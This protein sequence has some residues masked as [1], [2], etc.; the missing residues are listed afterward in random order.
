MGQECN[1]CLR[2]IPSG[3]K[4]IKDID[5]SATLKKPICS[6]LTTEDQP[7]EISLNQF[8]INKK[9]KTQISASEEL[10]KIEEVVSIS[11]YESKL[12]EFKE[13]LQKKLSK[14]ARETDGKLEYLGFEKQLPNAVILDDGTI[15]QG[16]LIENSIKSGKGLEVLIDGSKYVGEFKNNSREGLGRL[17][18]PNGDYYEGEF[19]N[20]KFNGKGK[21]ISFEGVKFEG[22][23]KGD[24]KNGYGKEEWTDGSVY[25]GFYEGSFK[26]GHGKFKWKD[27]SYYEGEFTDNKI[28]GKGIYYWSNGKCFE[29]EW[30]EN[31]M[32]GFGIFTWPSGRKYEGEYKSDL[33]D[34]KGKFTWPDGRVYDGD[35]KDG[36]QHG[37][38][39]YTFFN[40]KS[41]QFQTRKGRWEKGVRVDW[42]KG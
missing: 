18:Y 1:T 3:I 6:D 20:N 17:I 15:Y 35:W 7:A 19:R 12:P 22:N 28:Q 42:I 10:L 8:Q 23:F 33:K 31:K 25:E 39:N 36:Q 26:N 38:G 34:G 13:S 40:K 37:V 24:K 4:N 29:G 21:F 16:Y 27:G 14:K 11:S 9:V 30:K 5:L 32:D 41:N 2:G